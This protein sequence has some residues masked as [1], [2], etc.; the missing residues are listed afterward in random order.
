VLRLRR[1]IRDAQL[2]PVPT[3]WRANDLRVPANPQWTLD[4]AWAMEYMGVDGGGDFLAFFLPR[5][6]YVVRWFRFAPRS[7]AGWHVYT[8]HGRS[9]SAGRAVART[10]RV[11]RGGVVVMLVGEMNNRGGAPV[12]QTQGVHARWLRV[13]R[14]GSYGQRQTHRS[15][16]M[17]DWREGPGCRR[18]TLVGLRGRIENG[19]PVQDSAQRAFSF[20]FLLFLFSFM[21][22]LL[23]IFRFQI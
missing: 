22:S 23:P 3:H 7:R 14:V 21:F 18:H 9:D 2:R 12:I 10:R 8:P 5:G 11:C 19:L 17:R 16:C 15:A 1:A 13:W 20:F 4:R 6:G